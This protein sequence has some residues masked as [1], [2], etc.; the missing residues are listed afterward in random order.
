MVSFPYKVL[1]RDSVCIRLI[2]TAFNI[3]THWSNEKFGL[4]MAGTVFVVANGSFS[5]SA[6]N[7]SSAFRIE[8]EIAGFNWSAHNTTWFVPHVGI[9]WLQHTEG[10]WGNANIVWRL[11]HYHFVE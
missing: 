11:V 2:H 3:S 9:I 1:Y 7:F 10:I 6:G 5:V 8:E 4:N